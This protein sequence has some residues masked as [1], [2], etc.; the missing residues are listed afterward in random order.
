MYFKGGAKLGPLHIVFRNNHSTGKR[1]LLNLLNDLLTQTWISSSVFYTLNH[2]FFSLQ[3]NT[4]PVKPALNV[5]EE[6]ELKPNLFDLLELSTIDDKAALEQIL[7]NAPPPLSPSV[8]SNSAQSSS[9]LLSSSV[10]NMV[11]Y[12]SFYLWCFS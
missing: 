11:Y 6:F 3:Q 4:K 2:D 9:E 5:F 10:P 8:V 1:W 12:S 7:A